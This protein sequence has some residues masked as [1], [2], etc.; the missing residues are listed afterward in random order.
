[1]MRRST[2]IVLAVFV[3][4]VGFTIFFQRY[5]ANKS[6]NISTSTPTVPPAYLYELKNAQVND[7]KIADNAGKNIN[8]YRD[9]TSSKWTI[10]GIP[11]DQVDSSQIES[12]ASQLKSFQVQDTM[13]QTVSLA[14]IGLDKPAYTITLTTNDGS[15]LI[16]YIGM[17]TAIGTGYYVRNGTGQVMIVDKTT[18]DDIINLLKSPPLL[19]TATPEVTPTETVSPTQPIIQSTSTP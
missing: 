6:N 19:P 10:E 4:L 13:T 1:M 2:W 14:S 11:V 3:L 15:Q 17:Q 7:I 9:P 16:T 18:M 8:L 5:Q 12:I